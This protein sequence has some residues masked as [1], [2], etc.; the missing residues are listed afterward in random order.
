ML[1]KPNFIS[2]K[3]SAHAFTV[4]IL[5][6]LQHTL[7]WNN[8]LILITGVSL[9]TWIYTPTYWH[10]SPRHRYP[11]AFWDV[12][13]AIVSIFYP[14][15]SFP[16]PTLSWLTF[17]RTATDLRGVSMAPLDSL[18]HVSQN[19]HTE[20]MYIKQSTYLHLPY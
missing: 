20:V 11:P 10:W 12:F 16:Q 14:H 8:T 13:V 17:T 2:I 1:K 18:M 3:V 19:L 7:T 6:K 9:I 5:F 15:T 4:C